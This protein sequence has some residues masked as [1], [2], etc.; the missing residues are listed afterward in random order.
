MRK[1][2]TILGTITLTV[3]VLGVAGI[4]VLA[5]RGHTL[6]TESKA[7]VDRTVPVMIA[8]WSDAQLLDRLTPAQRA[9]ITPAQLASLAAAFSRL[10]PLVQ[11]EG[12]TGQASLAYTTGSGSV[13][14]AAYVVKAQF[15]AGTATI[16]VTVVKRDGHWMFAG[17]HVDAAPSGSA[18]QRV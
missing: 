18:E 10:G 14:S 12:A 15:S 7:F 2:L 5:Y 4:G 13:V 1:L 16:R 11:Y 6:D 3:I 8:H 9:S 17:F